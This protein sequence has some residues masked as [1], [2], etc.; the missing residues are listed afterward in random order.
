MAFERGTHTAQND[1]AKS[2]RDGVSELAHVLSPTAL[3]DVFVRESLE[4]AGLAD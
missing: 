3:E 2:D 1:F 4:A